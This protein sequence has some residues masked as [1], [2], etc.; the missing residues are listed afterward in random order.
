MGRHGVASTSKEGDLVS[1]LRD[2]ELSWHEISEDQLP[3]ALRSLTLEVRR[4]FVEDQ[5]DRRR[6]LLSEVAYYASK[7][8]AYLEELRHG[9][10]AKAFAQQV[11]NALLVGARPGASNPHRG[12]ASPGAPGGVDCRHEKIRSRTSE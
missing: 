1:K 9:D 6:G 7:R 8:D 11:V 12:S 2:A 3:E 5:I 10:P 4:T